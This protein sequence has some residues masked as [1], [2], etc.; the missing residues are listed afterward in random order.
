MQNLIIPEKSIFKMSEVCELTGVKP[1]VLRF[2]ESEF[3]EIEPVSSSNGQKLYERT[4]IKIV[5]YIKK[6]LFEDKLTIDHAK[7]KVSKFVTGGY[8]LETRV[9]NASVNEESF[10]D[11][12]ENQ[13]KPEQDNLKIDS[14]VQNEIEILREELSAIL[15]KTKSIQEAHNWL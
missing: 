13:V 4:D 2:W 11:N 9:S 5:A 14:K 1:Y 12:S 10:V 15:T 7:L 8:C 6:L 3:V